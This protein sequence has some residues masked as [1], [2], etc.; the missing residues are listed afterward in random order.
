MEYRECNK[1][2]ITDLKYKAC[3]EYDMRGPRMPDYNIFVGFNPHLKMYIVAVHPAPDSHCA[4]RILGSDTKLKTREDLIDCALEVLDQ[5][6]GNLVVYK[7]P[8]YTIPPHD[9]AI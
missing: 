9:N 7:E 5:V 2:I 1:R 6:N 4:I 8:G 3:R